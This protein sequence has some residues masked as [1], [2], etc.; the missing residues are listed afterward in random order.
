[1]VDDQQRQLMQSKKAHDVFAKLSHHNSV[2]IIT[3]TQNL[4]PAGKFSKD[5]RLNLHYYIIMRSFTFASQVKHL[6]LQLYPHDKNFLSD[7][8]KKACKAKFSYLVVSLHPVAE[9]LLRVVSKIFPPEDLIVF[10]P[11]KNE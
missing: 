1:M 9:D 10:V 4:F 5:F 7:A 11:K 8:Y 3:L 6:G 2:T